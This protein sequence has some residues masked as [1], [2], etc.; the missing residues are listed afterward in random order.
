MSTS[1]SGNRE[2]TRSGRRAVQVTALV[3]G[4]VF[5]LVGVLGFIPGVTTQAGDMTF[6]G[7]QSMSKLLGVFQVSVFHNIVH[8]LFGVLGIVASRTAR[9]ARTYLIVG[10]ALYLVL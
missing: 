10:G 3:F 7:H 9:A 6:A 5:L 1:I 8:L 4:V 2:G